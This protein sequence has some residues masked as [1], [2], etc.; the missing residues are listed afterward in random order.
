M[1]S[2]VSNSK[3]KKINEQISQGTTSYK[4]KRKL[5]HFTAHG[6][7]NI[8]HKEEIISNLIGALSPLQLRI[9]KNRS[10]GLGDV[11]IRKIIRSANKGI[12]SQ[13]KPMTVHQKRQAHLLL[14]H[15]GYSPEERDILNKNQLSDEQ[16]RR[17]IKASMI[18]S[19]FASQDSLHNRALMA[20][21]RLDKSARP[22]IGVNRNSANDSPV[23]KNNLA[24]PISGNS[25]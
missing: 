9:L 22:G 19:K 17:N 21:S 2:S 18:S 25:G 1:S 4:L 5:R 15:L 12:D 6:Q 7:F 13:G 10:K 16:K 14:K 8:L 24:T 3:F 11:Q 20:G 23:P